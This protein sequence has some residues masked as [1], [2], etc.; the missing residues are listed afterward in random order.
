[1]RPAS[2]FDPSIIINMHEC[3]HVTGLLNVP[4]VEEVAGRLQRESSDDS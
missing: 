4:S 2:A 3:R 1:M